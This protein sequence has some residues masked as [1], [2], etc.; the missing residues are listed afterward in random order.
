MF[1]LQCKMALGSNM[2][3]MHGDD[4]QMDS[5]GR[6]VSNGIWMR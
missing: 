6:Y 3:G 4:V 1:K 5:K 2:Q